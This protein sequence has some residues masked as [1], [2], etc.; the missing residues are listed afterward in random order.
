MQEWRRALLDSKVLLP[1]DIREVE[2]EV[3]QSY[4]PEAFVK[5]Y[6]ALVSGKPIPP[7]SPLIKLNPVLNE[8]GCIHSN[9]LQ[10]VEYLPYGVWFP[11]ILPQRHWV[12][13]LIVKYHYEQANHS[14]GTNLCA[15][16]NK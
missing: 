5:Q 13:K 11:K 16:P 6:R 3:V 2:D 4:Q 14:A 12:T 1:H 7:K 10:F 8:H 9:G 15:V